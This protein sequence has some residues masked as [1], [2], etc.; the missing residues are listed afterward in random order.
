MNKEWAKNKNEEL[1]RKIEND[2][3]ML[4]DKILNADFLSQK[5][6]RK[7]IKK[8]NKKDYGYIANCCEGECITR[9][10]DCEE[11]ERIRIKPLLDQLANVAR[12]LDS[13][14]CN[15]EPYNRYLD[16]NLMEF[17]GD[18][19]IT[20][21]CYIM[22]SKH[23]GTIPM[24]ENDWIESEYGFNMEKLGINNYMT[25]DTLYGDWS[26]TVYNTDTTEEI[27]EF[28]ADAGLVSVINWDEVLKYNPDFDY[29]IN[30]PWT[31]T[32]IKNFKGTVQF[33]VERKCGTYTKNDEHEFNGKLYNK[34]GT[35][36]ESFYVKV[37]GHGINTKTGEPINFK[38]FQTGL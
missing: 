16:S 28:C 29:H 9:L 34:E 12:K 33:V 7:L 23:H 14:K 21:P 4:Y 3:K 19:I 25:R 5:E 24:Y 35:F 22:R 32:L 31:V 17:D 30:K 6:K 38:G 8:F 15:S 27:G 10:I 1:K 26:C 13:Y 37:V 11:K 20:D 18:I 36:W 2:K